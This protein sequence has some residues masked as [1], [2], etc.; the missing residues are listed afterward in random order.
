M[1]YSLDA[2]IEFP[3]ERFAET[4]TTEFMNCKLFQSQEIQRRNHFH[5]RLAAT[6]PVFVAPA[7][8]RV[9]ANR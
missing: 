9:A 3:I 4:E 2:R 6:S 5:L 1:I 8:V 7:M